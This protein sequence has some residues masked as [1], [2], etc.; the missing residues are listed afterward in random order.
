MARAEPIAEAPLA[1]AEPMAR[2]ALEPMA[3]AVPAKAIAESAKVLAAGTA[4]VS[5]ELGRGV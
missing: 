2:V 1:K 3:R 4:A 5:T